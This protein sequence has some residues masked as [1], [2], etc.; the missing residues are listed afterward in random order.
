MR[1]P[2]VIIDQP[3]LS[4]VDIARV[5]DSAQKNS[6]IQGAIHKAQCPEYLS[7]EQIKRKSHE[8]RAEQN[9]ECKL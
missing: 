5:L 1:Q 3:D 2:T 9:N 8:R 7:W 6:K 4:N